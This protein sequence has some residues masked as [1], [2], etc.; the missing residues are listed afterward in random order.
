MDSL[1]VVIPTYNRRESLKRTLEGLSRQT[2]PHD[3]FEVVVVSDGSEDG[4]DEMLASAANSMSYRLRA[5]RQ[6]N[7]GPAAARNRGVSEAAGEI[8]LFIDDDVEPVPD[9]IAWHRKHHEAD[10]KIAVL[11]LMSP[12]PA[13]RRAEPVWIAWEHAKLQDIYNLFRPGGQF[14]G[15][16]AGPMHFYS[17]N[18][19]V[20]KQWILAAGGFDETYAR[21]EDVE[22]AVRMERDCGVHFLFEFHADGIHRPIRSYESWARIPASYGRLDARRVAD[23]LLSWDIV[24]A[25]AEGRHRATRL[26]SEACVD[27]PRLA[28]IAMAMLKRAALVLHAAG[29]TSAALSALSAL[30]NL[31]YIVEFRRTLNEANQSHVPAAGGISVD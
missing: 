22:L 14:Y 15:C 10:D 17:G 31:A 7:A 24:R 28:P 29:A 9:L 23:G 4:T 8:I 27:S 12:D 16:P 19:S 25:R 5:I 21:Q 6:D 26:I 2:E 1:S 13:N 18:A 20:R 3:S 30:Y 11:G